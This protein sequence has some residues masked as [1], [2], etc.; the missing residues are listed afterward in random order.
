MEFKLHQGENGPVAELLGT[1]VQVKDVPD[2]LDL[3]ANCGARSFIVREEHLPGEF[4]QLKT[5]LAGDIL[6][7]FTNYRVRFGR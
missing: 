3:M 4:F 2:A 6:Q 1:G 7:K 5:R